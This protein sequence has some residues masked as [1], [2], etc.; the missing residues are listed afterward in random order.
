MNQTEVQVSSGHRVLLVDDDVALCN[1]LQEYLLQENLEVDLIHRGDQALAATKTNHYDLVVL[2][3]MLPGLSGTEVLKQIRAYSSLPVLMLTARGDDID[4]IVGLE[5]GADDYLPKP[6]NPRE[7]LARIRAILRR[8][9]TPGDSTQAAGPLKLDNLVLEPGNRT[10]TAGGIPVELT[11]TEFTLLQILMQNAGQIV[12]K[13]K[14]SADGLGRVLGRHDRSI[15]MH[16]SNIRRKLG[17]DADGDSRIETVRG[18]G[19]LIKVT[20][21]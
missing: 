1:L 5:M 4:R 3:V 14:L 9:H 17:H 16:L 20:S 21:Q 7:L 12:N 19:Y 2:D 15:D 10:L 18:V 13:E 8:A 11:S 6:C